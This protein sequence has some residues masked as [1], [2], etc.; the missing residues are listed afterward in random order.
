MV[1]RHDMKQH[2]PEGRHILPQ[3]EHHHTRGHQAHLDVTEHTDPNVLITVDF[4]VSTDHGATWQYGGGFTMRGGT[5]D[6]EGKPIA[7]IPL[8]KYG[9]PMTYCLTHFGHELPHHDP[10]HHR[11]P[12][13]HRL[14]KGTMTIE[15]GH[16]QTRLHVI[17]TPGAHHDKSLI[18]TD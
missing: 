8:D 7:G 3:Q 2:V 4:E 12:A 1:I 9:E 15:G 14:V 6:A 5:V 16:V 10:R 13:V 18:P 17:G 11:E